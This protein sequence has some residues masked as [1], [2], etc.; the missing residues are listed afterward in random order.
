MRVSFACQVSTSLLAD[1]AKPF[2][3]ALLLFTSNF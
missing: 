2:T 3:L 1:R